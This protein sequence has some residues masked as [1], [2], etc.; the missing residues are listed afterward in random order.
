MPRKPRDESKATVSTGLRTRIVTLSE[1]GWGGNRS[2]MSRDLDLDLSTISKVLGNKQEPTAKLLERLAA[3]PAFN[4]GYLFFG[5]GQPL[6]MASPRS[7]FGPFRPVL[8]Q[9]VLGPPEEHSGCLTSIG[10][11]VAPAFDT[12]SSFWFRV[13]PNSP[14]TMAKE[15][16]YGV[17]GN[18]LMLMDTHSKWTRSADAVAGRFCGYLFGSGKRQRVILAFVDG[19]DQAGPL[20][21]YKHHRVRFF[22]EVEEMNLIVGEDAAAEQAA[23]RSITG[24]SLTLERVACVCL[25]LERPFVKG[26]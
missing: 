9:L 23:L 1:L 3:W 4:P 21:R 25:K 10:Y 15:I 26:A 12:P 11:P 7:S 2:Q 14:I 24:P 18:D 5:H 20:E 6:V 16:N 17:R 22:D 19:W 13:L 8:D